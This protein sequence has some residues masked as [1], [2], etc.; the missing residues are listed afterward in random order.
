MAKK[1]K[2]RPE[3]PPAPPKPEPGPPGPPGPMGPPGPAGPTGATGLAGPTGPEG[4]KHGHGD[5]LGQLRGSVRALL[6]VFAAGSLNTEQQKAIHAVK[7]VIGDDFGPGCAHK[8]TVYE[9]GDKLVCQ[10]CRSEV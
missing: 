5:L 3:P 8:N 7:V 2:T 10:D 6:A 9:A 4:P 1:P